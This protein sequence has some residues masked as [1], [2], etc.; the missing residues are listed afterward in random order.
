MQAKKIDER[1]AGPTR[2]F[3]TFYLAGRLYGVDILH[4]KEIS[5][6]VRFTP[7]YH[8]P[9]EVMGFVNIRGQIHLVLDLQMLL[10]QEQEVEAEAGGRSLLVIF[11]PVVGESFGVLIDRIGD[12]VEIAEDE[13]EDRRKTDEAP[14]DS[15]DRRNEGG[16]LV[17]GVCKLDSGLLIALNAKR[18]LEAVQV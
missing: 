4:V 10:G 2:K 16:N 15:G 12:V 18:F 8:A 6:V 13:I 5:S 9:R 1:S 7:I 11:K 17:C 3:C 14:P